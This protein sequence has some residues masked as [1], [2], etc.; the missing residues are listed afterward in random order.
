[1]VEAKDPRDGQAPSGDWLG[2]RHVR[3][4]R[5]GPLAHCVIDR[6]EKRNAM[7]SAMYFAVRYATNHVDADH[8][9]A[10]LLIIGSGDVFI[11]GGDLSQQSDDDWDNVC[12]LLYMD[13]CPF[14]A[15]RQASKPVVSAINGICQGGGLVIAMLSDVSVASDR[16]TF[17]APELLRGI[18]DTNYAADSSEANRPGAGPGHAV[19]RKGGGRSGGTRMGAHLAGRAAR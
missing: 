17:R 8:D 16:A 4:E 15:L 1:M 14:D 18:A 9:L 12:G 10:G 13:V 7:T 19:D 3:F 2:T 11:P 6:A 5:H